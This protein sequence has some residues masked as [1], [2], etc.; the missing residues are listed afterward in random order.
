[1]KRRRE[2]L[3]PDDS[4]GSGGDWEGGKSSG[5]HGVAEGEDEEMFQILAHWGSLGWWM[6]RIIVFEKNQ[7]SLEESASCA[8]S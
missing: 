8:R 5:G 3:A 7:K 1:M 6:R 2:V 4:A